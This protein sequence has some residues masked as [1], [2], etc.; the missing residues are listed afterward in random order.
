M[1]AGSLRER[2]VL[3]AGSDRGIASKPVPMRRRHR[4]PAGG[5]LSDPGGDNH[6][7]R[8][9][10]HVRQ[11]AELWSAPSTNVLPFVIRP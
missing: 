7:V 9:L 8:L 2:D 10:A 4:G 6:A 5:E 1:A 11:E 3:Q